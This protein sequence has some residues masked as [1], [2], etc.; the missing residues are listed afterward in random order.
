[1]RDFKTLNVWKTAHRLTL[2]VYRV[3]AS[4]PKDEAYG[5]VSQM[6]RASVSIASNIAEGCGRESNL[7]M[8]RFLSIAAGSASELQYQILLARD[9]GMLDQ[10]SCADLER[11]VIEVR[12]MASS[13]MTKLKTKRLTPDT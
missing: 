4:F 9:L 12:K 6:R 1:M 3:C 11:N 5:L 2:K 7:E 8:A 10:G 13:F